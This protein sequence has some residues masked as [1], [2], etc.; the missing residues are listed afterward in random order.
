MKNHYA[1]LFVLLFF[2]SIQAQVAIYNFDDGTAND[3]I[4]NRDGVN[5]GATLNTDRFGNP[6]SVFEYYGLNDNQITYVGDP[7]IDVSED[8]S[9]T[10]WFYLN[11]V[12]PN[13]FMYMVTSRKDRF[14][15]EVGG[16]D[17]GVKADS[18]FE[19]LCRKVAPLNVVGYLNPSLKLN[20]CEWHFLGLTVHQD[21][22]SLYLNSEKVGE[23]LIENYSSGT[24]ITTSPFW[25][26]GGN[27]SNFSTI[28]RE[29]DGKLDDIRFFD[30]AISEKEIRDLYSFASQSNSV[31]KNELLI[32]FANPNPA[33][34]FLFIKNDVL[35]IGQ[36]F[37]IVNLTG[38]TQQSG[39][40]NSTRIS[41][42]NLP[43]GLYLLQIRDENH[44]VVARQKVQKTTR[45]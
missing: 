45:S 23:S 22:I 15:A 30:K 29:L 19:L 31:D 33:T 10:Y 26:F 38:A 7:I 41:L 1:T 6:N 44:K 2:S 17:M 37:E 43:V 24:R 42:S 16:V 39:I 34:D 40:L 8:F 28:Y 35:E 3:V 13:D 5:M 12:N 9:I 21:T 36:Y 20:R 18:T 11:S 27:F 25:T 32:N 4:G 14:G